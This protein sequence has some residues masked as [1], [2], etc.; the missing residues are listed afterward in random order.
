MHFVTDEML[1]KVYEE[2]I[3]HKLDRDFISLLDAEITKRG[4]QPSRS[5]NE[6]GVALALI[7]NGIG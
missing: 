3:I 1:L 5:K 2:A 4:L 6:E 7:N